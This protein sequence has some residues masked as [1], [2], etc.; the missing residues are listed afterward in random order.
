MSREVWVQKWEESEAG[1]GVRPDGYT[2]HIR[3]E[4]IDAFLKD[5]RDR[6]FETHGGATPPEYSRPSG[7]PYLAILSG[8]S[9]GAAIEAKLLASSHGIWGPGGNNYPESA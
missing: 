9:D 4:D 2:F 1:W 5:L 6:E 8:D 3:R 7:D